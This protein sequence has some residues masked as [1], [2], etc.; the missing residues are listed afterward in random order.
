MKI[1][2]YI[3]RGFAL[4]RFWTGSKENKYQDEIIILEYN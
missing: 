1:L 4:K 2:G 3:K